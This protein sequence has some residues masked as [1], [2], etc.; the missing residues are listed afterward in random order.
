VSL[1]LEYEQV[2]KRQAE[3]LQITTEDADRFVAALCARMQLSPV[4]FRWRPGLRDAKDDHVLELAVASG[5][6]F[7]ITYKRP[8]SPV[9]SSSE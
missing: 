3:R 7:I 8:T 4:W 9:P 6:Q 5:S 1:L 2:I